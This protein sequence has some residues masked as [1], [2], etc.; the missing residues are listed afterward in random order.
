MKTTI[1]MMALLAVCLVTF[2]GCKKAEQAEALEFNGVKVDLPKLDVVFVGA[3]DQVQANVAMFK[4][5][6]RYGQYPQA[7]AELGRLASQ[8]SLTEPQKK[9]VNDLTEQVRQ[10]IAK[11][12]RRREGE[13]IRTVHRDGKLLA[14]PDAT[15]ASH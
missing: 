4:R 1:G 2:A 9:L 12:P 11:A 14:Q 10:V 5:F 3:S 6:F 7:L 13:A 15:P 8:P